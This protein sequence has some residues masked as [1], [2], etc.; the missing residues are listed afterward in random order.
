M[1]VQKVQ[2]QLFVRLVHEDVEAHANTVHIVGGP[3]RK[4]HDVLGNQGNPK[5]REV[6]EVQ[7][8]LVVREDLVV[9]VNLENLVVLM[10]LMVQVVLMAQAIL[11]S[12]AV[13]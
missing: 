1:V 6:L 8:L 11:A 13:R 3:A 10:C 2:K 5:V 12:L 7:V 9:Q 4:V